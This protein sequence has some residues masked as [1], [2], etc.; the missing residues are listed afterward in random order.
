MPGL[1]VVAREV[2]GLSVE[3]KEVPGLSVEANVVQGELGVGEFGMDQYAERGGFKM[4]TSL[5]NNKLTVWW[6]QW[7]QVAA[8]A[9]G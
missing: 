3:A 1:S 4:R 5:L 8:T 7:W 9:H 6:P 2:P